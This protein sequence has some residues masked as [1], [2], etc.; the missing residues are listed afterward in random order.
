MTEETQEMLTERA[1]PES[2]IVRGYCTNFAG[3]MRVVRVMTEKDLGMY[4]GH[5]HLYTNRLSL[6]CSHRIRTTET[7]KEDQ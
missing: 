2:N 3:V 5:G 1:D 6:L 7:K 4:H